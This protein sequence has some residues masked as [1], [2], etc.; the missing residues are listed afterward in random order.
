MLDLVDLGPFY[1]SWLNFVKIM[2]II[3]LRF[4]EFV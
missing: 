4:L 1:L 2:E 3:Y